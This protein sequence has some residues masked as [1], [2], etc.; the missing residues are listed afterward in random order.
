MHI[1]L[2]A[3]GFSIMATF[4][5]CGVGAQVQAQSLNAHIGGEHK[6]YT[7]ELARDSGLSASINVEFA[8]KL[9][10]RL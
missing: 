6:T 10:Q 5:S 7:N 9:A 2:R 3:A 8:S 4:V 1:A